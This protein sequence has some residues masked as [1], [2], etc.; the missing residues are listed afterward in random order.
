MY[1]IEDVSKAAKNSSKERNTFKDL[2][3]HCSVAIM[4]FLFS[5]FCSIP[6]WKSNNYLSIG[7][8]FQSSRSLNTASVKDNKRIQA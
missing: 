3:L 8:Q 1:L 4:S 7:L 5:S 6:I 2:R